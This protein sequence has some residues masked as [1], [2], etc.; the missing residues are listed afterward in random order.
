MNRTQVVDKSKVG[1]RVAGYFLLYYVV[2]VVDD[3]HVERF[4]LA[5]VETTVTQ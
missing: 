1:Y 2:V 3:S 5:T 4:V